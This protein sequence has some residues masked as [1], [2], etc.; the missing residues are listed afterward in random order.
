MLDS[1]ATAALLVI[2]GLGAGTLGSMVGIGGGLIMTPALILMG[3]PPTQ[4]SSTSLFAVTCTSASSTL[5]YAKQKRINY[6]FG[7]KLAFLAIPGAVVGA[8]ISG[9][10]PIQ[11]FK[12][13]FGITLMLAG[14]YLSFNGPIGNRSL[15]GSK[16]SRKFSLQIL[17]YSCGFGAGIASS[18]F[19]IGGGIVFVPLLVLIFGMTLSSASPTSQF[20]LLITS[21]VGSIT[22]SLLGH[23]DYFYAATLS[24]GAFLGGQI[25]AN[26]SRKVK[27]T[28]LRKMLSISLLA[29]SLK[30][31][32]DFFNL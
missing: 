31:I 8:L 3:L 32:S 5:S 9:A 15:Q 24:I 1:F 20:A 12:L 22:H 2:V 6:Q 17:F 28:I 11:S 4:I 29:V 18:L 10:V 25:G 23:P 19:G 21:L 16:R 13:Y 26:V 30:F 14:I 27:E 7:S